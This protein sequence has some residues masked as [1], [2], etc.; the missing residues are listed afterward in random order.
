MDFSLEQLQAYVAVYEQLSF[1]KAAVKLN[2]H[3][4]TIGQ[5]IGNLED[6]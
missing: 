2:K 4:T 3:R 6:Q 1:S 5:V